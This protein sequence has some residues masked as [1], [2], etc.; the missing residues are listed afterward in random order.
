M[1]INNQ[2]YASSMLPLGV[3]LIAMSS[4]VG[5]LVLRTVVAVVAPSYLKVKT[6]GA[7]ERSNA[8]SPQTATVRDRWKIVR[9]AP[10]IRRWQLAPMRREPLLRRVW[11]VYSQLSCAFGQSAQMIHFS[12]GKFGHFAHMHCEWLIRTEESI[13][14]CEQVMLYKCTEK[15]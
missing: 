1:V 6:C 7:S 11:N 9:K 13:F 14:F 4:A 12:N 3:K 8:V 15:T 2:E 5:E 10:S